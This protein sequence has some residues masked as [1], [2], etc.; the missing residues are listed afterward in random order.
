MSIHISNFSFD[1][2]GN[3]PKLWAVLSGI[4]VGYAISDL[5]KQKL[6]TIQNENNG[7]ENLENRNIIAVENQSPVNAR[8]RAI[9]KRKAARA[10][11][12]SCVKIFARTLGLGFNLILYR[13][14]RLKFPTPTVL[15]IA[16]IYTGSILGSFAVNY[17]NK[18][19][20]V[21]PI[22]ASTVVYKSLSPLVHP[23]IALANTKAV[24]LGTCLAWPI[25]TSG[26]RLTLGMGTC[27]A[28]SYWYLTT[29][30]IDQ[31]NEVLN[32]ILMRNTIQ[33]NL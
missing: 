2:S 1:V 29:L 19:R 8:Q 26:E 13:M 7:E 22:V 31:Q 20:I 4:A 6:Q 32:K 15:K 25:T 14:V 16:G 3:F 9:A 18:S 21:V 24:F 17:F 23:M 27:L 11:V 12:A 28:Y 30:P 10:E 5:V 33:S